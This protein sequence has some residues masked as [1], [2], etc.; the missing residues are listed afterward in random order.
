MVVVSAEERMRLWARRAA[1]KCCLLG[2]SYTI[3]EF[4]K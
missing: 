2:E 4:L 1:F 3:N